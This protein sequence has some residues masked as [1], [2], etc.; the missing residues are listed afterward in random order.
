[1]ILGSFRTVQQGDSPDPV[2]PESVDLAA[3]ALRPVV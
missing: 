2:L 3:G 1:M